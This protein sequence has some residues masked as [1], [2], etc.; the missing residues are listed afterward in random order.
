MLDLIINGSQ[1]TGWVSAQ[2]TSTMETLSDE[3]TVTVSQ[4]DPGSEQVAL[5]K[6]W[7]KAVVRYNGE[8]LLTGYIT[9][10]DAKLG[11]GESWSITINDN[12]FDLVRACRLGGPFRWA[13]GQRVESILTQLC[14]PH[15]VNVLV[16]GNTGK[17]L[18]AVEMS[19]EET[20]YSMIQK[21]CKLRKLMAR[22]TPD[23]HLELFQSSARQRHPGKLI[24][25]GDAPTLLDLQRTRDTSKQHSSVDVVGQSELSPER[26]GRAATKHRGRATNASVPRYI[27]LVMGADEQA[28]KIGRAHV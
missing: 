1:F 14:K 15:G 11:N 16:R 13:K 3:C 17:P 10:D 20:V 12:T 4:W 18:D 28:E 27:P 25:G 19:Q 22:A 8:L 26:R 21:L 24:Y 5:L 9:K 23:G 7:S 6:P 2:I